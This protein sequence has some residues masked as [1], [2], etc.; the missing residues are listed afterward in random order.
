MWR[1]LIPDWGSAPEIGQEDINHIKMRKHVCPL[2]DGRSEP[3]TASVNLDC[4]NQAAWQTCVI[5]HF[6]KSLLP[7]FARSLP[8]VPPH[9]QGPTLYYSSPLPIYASPSVK[10]KWSRRAEASSWKS[11]QKRKHKMRCLKF[12]EQEVYWFWPMILISI[13][14]S[15]SWNVRMNV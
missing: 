10:V 8:L 7:S 11:K 5:Q 3:P 6:V 13:C 14:L 9:F 1:E 4:I 12:L 2:T 15:Y